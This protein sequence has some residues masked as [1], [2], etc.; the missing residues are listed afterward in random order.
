MSHFDAAALE[1]LRAI[2]AERPA[3][4]LDGA[5]LRRAAVLIPL[6]ASGDGWDILFAKRSE[7]LAVHKGQVA[8][9]GGSA[10]AG[11][12]PEEAALR[13]SEEEVGLPARDVELIGRLDDLITH[14][15]FIV[16]PF[17][18]IV[19][20]RPEY[21]LEPAEVDEVFEVP[22]DLLLARANPQIRYVTWHEQVYPTYVFRHEGVEIWGMTGRILKGFLDLVRLA[23]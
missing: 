13:E 12:S 20:G 21:V 4:E 22:I 3:D 11:E 2:L 17:V 10:E 23:M 7:N 1:R 14:T 18:G 16:A 6:I 8:F 15:G 9:P 5:N 19:S